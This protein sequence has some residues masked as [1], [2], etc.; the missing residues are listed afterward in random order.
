MLQLTYSK[1]NR[2][3]FTKISDMVFKDIRK[4]LR[5]FKKLNLTAKFNPR[6]L[7]VHLGRVI[8]KS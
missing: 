4:V 8:S 1:N 2:L 6:L 7:N 5:I 3:I